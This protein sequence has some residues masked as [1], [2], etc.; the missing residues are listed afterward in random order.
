MIR[1]G[2]WS[3]LAAT[4]AF[5]VTSSVQGQTL[6]PKAVAQQVATQGQAQVAGT[7]TNQA[8]PAQVPGYQGTDIA[9][10]QYLD[11][12]SQL[13]GD[14]AT[15]A[16]SSQP[17]QIVVD[18]ARAQYTGAP[19]A[20]A[21]AKIV[22]AN[23]RSFTGTGVSAGASQ[24]T[25]IQLPASPPSQTVYYD[26]CEI[27]QAETDQAVTCNVGWN[28][29]VSV[30][31]KYTCSTT[32]ID[33]RVVTCRT[34]DGRFCTNETVTY[35]PFIT[36]HPGNASISSGTGSVSSCTSLAASA[37]C[38]KTSSTIVRGVSSAPE[39][40]SDFV[41]GATM[42]RE[43]DT[44]S[45]SAVVTPMAAQ[46]ENDTV[47]VFTGRAF[48]SAN[49][50]IAN[51]ATVD[52]GSTSTYSG[53]TIENSDCQAKTAGLTC[54]PP[55]QVCTDASPTTRTIDGVPVE[56]DCWQWQA[57]YQ[58]A[59]LTPANSCA[60]IQARGSCSF[61]HEQCLDD[62]Q[63]GDCKV[64][65][66][67]YKCTTPNA[68]QNPGVQTC[69]G[70]VYCLDGSCTQLPTSPT[71]DIANALVAINAM[72][73]ATKQFDPN[74][75]TIFD[76]TATGCHKPLFGLV[77]CCAGKVS[78]MLTAASSA[79]ALA[80]ILTGSYTFLLSMVTQFLVLF[81]CSQQEMLLDVEDRMGLC[82]Y[83]GEYCS[84]KALFVCTTKRLTYCCYQSELARVIQEQGRAQLGL[85][86]G[87]PQN[88]N[89]SGF[90]VAQFSQLDLSK[91]DF[92]EVFSNFT[93]AVSLPSSLQTS[94]QIQSQVQQYYQNAGVGKP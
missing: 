55:T 31:H 16:A 49:W 59:T 89:C 68:A 39:L 53:S 33:E 58:C 32:T 80:G 63:V 11:N 23:P 10:S 70:D 92:S 74:A 4:Y 3:C 12:P 20:L 13:A 88:P 77:N 52:D 19:A 81:L 29:Q 65:S 90:T 44:Y 94:A 1:L 69:G 26:S 50:T 85:N 84:Q 45:C 2:A 35:V 18:P 37:Q 54:E 73:D 79:V 72:G 7:V 51:P 71:P 43:T 9:Q 82:T 24:G 22:E 6:D 25:C 57:T 60:T 86:F 47:A 28:N 38:S 40:I 64:K 83:V 61:D 34:P 30:T 36:G 17:Y 42:D 91:M 21:N 5:I 14:G 8:S 62:P 66:E 93:S 78:G 48:G 76:G 87:T 56:H 27:G 41:S 46:N 15:V 75:L 67:V